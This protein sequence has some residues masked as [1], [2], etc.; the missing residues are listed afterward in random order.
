MFSKSFL[1]LL[2]LL[3]AVLGAVAPAFQPAAISPL[4]S[5]SNYTGASNSTLQ[6]SAVVP[7]KVFDRFIQVSL[8]SLP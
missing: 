3:P 8:F 6:K 1:T 7:G 4:S 5:S 2:T